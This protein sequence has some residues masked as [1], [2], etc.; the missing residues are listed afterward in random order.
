MSRID[1]DA[2]AFGQ[3]SLHD[4][5]VY[6]LVFQRYEHQGNLLLDI[7]YIAEWGQDDDGKHS[8]LVAPA[9]LTFLDVVDLQVHLDWGNRAIYE[10]KPHGVIC[11]PSGELIVDDFNRFAHTDPLYTNQP[12]P[13][14]R[15]ELSFWQP[16][17]ARI[18]LGATD[19]KMVGR[20]E[21]VCSQEQSLDPAQR[22]PFVCGGS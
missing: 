22:P 5:R 9:T 2:S 10:K 14:F 8:F 15:Y 20:Q 6:A 18:A 11:R 1:L 3:F 13:Y 17:G 21:A 4:A 19:F 12:K 16:A 7:D